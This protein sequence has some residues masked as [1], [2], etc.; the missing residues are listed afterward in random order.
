MRL[1]FLGAPGAG[2]G[3]QAQKLCEKKE[4]PHISTGDILRE[5]VANKTQVGL[6][7]KSY[8]DQGK[9]VP[10]E[11]VVNIVSERLQKPDCKKGFLLDGFPRSLKQAEELDNKLDELGLNIDKVIYFSVDEDE[12]VRRITGRRICSKCG[13]NYHIESLKPKKDGICDKCSSELYQRNDDTAETVKKRLD[14]F[15]KESMPL[16]NYYK[17]KSL[18]TEIV[19]NKSIDEIFNEVIEVFL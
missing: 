10:D 14:V 12:V 6:A 19:A 8:M 16:V 18:L 1:I 13:E 11:V 2:K 5:A 4:I 7:A 17:N 15:K 3:T 9:L